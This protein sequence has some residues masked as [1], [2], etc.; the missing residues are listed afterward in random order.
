[1]SKQQRCA[2]CDDGRGPDSMN[3]ERRLRCPACGLPVC[4]DCFKASTPTDCNH[5]SMAGEDGGAP[6]Q[7][8]TEG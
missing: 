5:F 8:G 7:E 4:P 6:T 2:H 1:M 3:Y